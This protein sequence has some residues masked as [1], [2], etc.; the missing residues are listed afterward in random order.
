[1]R[2]GLK[3]GESEDERM[4]ETSSEIIVVK[5]KVRVKAKTDGHGN[6]DETKS[7]EVG[8]SKSKE[9]ENGSTADKASTAGKEE[10]EQTK[11]EQTKKDQTK[12]EQNQQIKFKKVLRRKLSSL[13][14]PD[15]FFSKTLLPLPQCKSLANLTKEHFHIVF[16]E[17]SFERFN[18][19]RLVQLTEGTEFKGGK[20]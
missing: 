15:T 12:T 20:H 14:F 5:K 19:F 3:C 10:T 13:E 17:G 1:L 18:H 9:D 11:T 8:E 4:I 2:A 7:K 6:G 16:G